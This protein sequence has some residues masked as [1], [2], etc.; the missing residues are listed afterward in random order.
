LANA[1]AA[2]N[3]AQATLAVST[4]NA[5]PRTRVTLTAHVAGNNTPEGVVNFRAGALDLG[6]AIV[7]AEGNASVETD[8]LPAGSHQVVAVYQGPS[9]ASLS[10]TEVV[11]AHV[12]AVAGFTVAASPT[13]LTTVAGGYLNSVVT[14]TPNNGF[15]GYVSLSCKG[16]PINTTCAFT[17]V[18]VQATC[19]GSTCTPVTSTMQIQTQAPSPITSQLD[20]NG[21]GLPKYAFVFPALFGLVG[22]G[23]CKRRTLRNL[24]LGLITFAGVLGMSSCAQR[25]KYLNHG[26]P[27]NP[28]SLLGT[29][30][31]TIESQSST[32]S[33]T[34][35]PPTSPTLTLTITKS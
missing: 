17:P 25:Y 2:V 30:T 26:P 19:T 4:N 28:G 31:V 6:S 33:Q 14:V 18:A 22:L 34:T 11:Q 5:G 12:A 10:N 7:D 1:Q 32:G 20:G 29:Y 24:A 35:V 13:T 23:A 27:G 9:G 3:T 21:D 16:L 15:S 8:I